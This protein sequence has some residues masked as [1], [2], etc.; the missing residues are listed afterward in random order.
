MIRDEVRLGG[1]LVRVDDRDGPWVAPIVF[2]LADEEQE[3]ETQACSEPGGGI[4]Q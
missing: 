1:Y 3:G 4:T 2:R